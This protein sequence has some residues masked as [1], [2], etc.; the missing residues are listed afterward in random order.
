MN[1]SFLLLSIFI[2]SVGFTQT[3]NDSITR[4]AL[5][6]EIKQEI[7]A[8]LSAEKAVEK[9]KKTDLLNW[10]KFGLEGYGVINYYQYDYDTDPVLKDQIDAERLNL[11]LSYQFSDKISFKSEIEFE[12]G[13]TGVAVSYDNQEEFGEFE[14]EIEKGGSV[15]LEQINLT[16]KISKHF[17]IRAGRVKLNIGIASNLDEPT[18]YFTT[19][20]PEMES[21]IL[22][23]GWYEN[24]LEIFGKFA[25]RFNY[26]FYFVNGLDATGFSSRGWIK[27]GYQTRFEMVNA[28]SFAIAGRLDYSFGNDKHNFFGI[29]AYINDAAANRPK[30]DMSE[31]AYVTLVEAHINYNKN[32]FR[33]NAEALYGNLENSN[34]VS[35]QNANLSNNLGVKRTAVGKNAVGFSAEAG[36]NV[37][38]WVFSNTTQKLFPFLRYDF[39]DTMHEVEGAIIDNPRWQRSTIT[40]GINWFILPK[41]VVKA[42]YS[43]RRLGSQ[44]YDLNTLKYTGEKQ[45]ER[46]FSVGLGFE[47]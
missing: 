41:I 39:Y 14:H 47:F 19:T 23:M 32:N 22:P 42:Q 11:Y 34:I 25:K 31:T 5:K 28:E 18:D 26:Q 27:N 17:N 4:A 44:N 40:A 33:F 30:N 20:R 3:K 29:S 7:L 12:H 15:K 6:K 9:S 2:S 37:L 16:F 45:H 10:N 13:G 35:Q 24:G 1:K 8:E 36:Y 43:D 46:S 21:E 38:P